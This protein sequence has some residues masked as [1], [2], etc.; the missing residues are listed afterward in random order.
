MTEAFRVRRSGVAAAPA[1]EGLCAMQEK[2][3]IK[4]IPLWAMIVLDLLALGVCLVVF[5][6]FHHVL[7]RSME[8]DAPRLVSAT[9]APTVRPAATPVPAA[10]PD[11]SETE[12]PEPI[13][14]DTRSEWAIRFEDHFTE[15]VVV[16]ENSYSSP[17]VS[18]TV[19]QR[20]IQN[21]DHKNVCYIADIYIADIQC[22]R[23]Y[24]AQNT[25]GRGIVQDIVDMARDSGAIAAMTGD[26][27]TYQ[28]ASLMLRNGELY[29]DGRWQTYQTHCALYYDG[30]MVTYGPEEIDLE[31]A[32]AE[33][34]RSDPAAGRRAAR[35][36]QQRHGSG[37]G[38]SPCGAGL[39]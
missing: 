19:T 35:R 32:M 39:L 10:E 21:G 38:K 27:Y 15:E 37:I 25:F 7:P 20:E 8:S 18:V 5:A 17:N 28:G 9:P 14:I 29:R 24:L 12:P 31:T 34:V 33:G 26:M 2:E 1:P 22:F 6:L 3:K 4:K 30:R 13:E 23:T 11:V 16:T 36:F